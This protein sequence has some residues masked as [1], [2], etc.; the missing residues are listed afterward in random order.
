MFEEG[1]KSVM[2]YAHTREGAGMDQWQSLAEHLDEVA[3]RAEVHATAF[4]SSAW[5][6]LAGRWHDLGKYADDF[7]KYLRQLAEDPAVLD[8]SVEDG[9]R[10]RVDHSSGRS[11]P[12]P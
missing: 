1:M 4:G 9:N 5:G 7:Q 8:V 11:R 3:K 10:H 12:G 2:H 6:D